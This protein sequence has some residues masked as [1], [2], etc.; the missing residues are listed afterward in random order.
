MAGPG[1]SNYLQVWAEKAPKLCRKTSE[2]HGRSAHLLVNNGFQAVWL[3]GWLRGKS[4]RL[5]ASRPGLNLMGKLVNPQ[6][7]I[8]PS[9]QQS[10]GSEECLMPP[11]SPSIPGARGNWRDADPQPRP[12]R[13]LPSHCPDCQPGPMA[14][15]FSLSSARPGGKAWSP[16]PC[17]SIPL[18]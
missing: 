14:S 2:S 8:S 4:L 18:P 9:S 7:S 15:G 11:H 1:L 17:I 3:A 5:E 6:A 10:S 16:S 13:A 12:G